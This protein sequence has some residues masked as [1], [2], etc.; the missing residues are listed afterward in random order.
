MMTPIIALA[1]FLPATGNAADGACKTSVIPATVTERATIAP[2]FSL[3][4]RRTE[5]Q[6]VFRFRKRDDPLRRTN[7]AAEDPLMAMALL[8]DG[9]VLQFVRDCSG[10]RC[11][12]S[13]LRR[14][15]DTSAPACQELVGGWP[16]PM[17]RRGVVEINPATQLKIGTGSRAGELSLR[18][19]SA[20]GWS[21]EVL[22][23]G[24]ERIIGVGVGPPLH[25]QYYDVHVIR[26]HRDG[27]ISLTAYGLEPF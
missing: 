4:I 18:Q 9:S 19:K 7:L 21:E 17:S 26:R 11:I 6:I 8:R 3:R 2:P 5:P 20:R 27:S 13:G 22:L 24:D 23:A 25:G 10:M 12:Y 15:A 14:I 16:F 1:L